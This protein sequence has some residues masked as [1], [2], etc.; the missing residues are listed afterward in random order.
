MPDKYNYSTLL[1]ASDFEKYVTL[2]GTYAIVVANAARSVASDI[3]IVIPLT[4]ERF[5][6]SDD[7][8][9]SNYF[10]RFTRALFEYFDNSFDKGFNCSLLMN[11]KQTP[12][13]IEE[14][15]PDSIIAVNEQNNADVFYAGTH[16]ALSE[17]I[18]SLSKLFKSCPENYIFEWTPNREL[19]GNALSVAYVYSYYSLLNDKSVSAFVTDLSQED[20]NLRDISHILK[21]IDASEGED[22]PDMLTSFF[23]KTSWSEILGTGTTVSTAVKHYFNSTP[24]LNTNESFFGEFLYFDP[25]TTNG[26]QTWQRGINCTGIETEYTQEHSRAL[27]ADISLYG[28]ESYGE[29][30]YVFEYPENM[31]YTNN[32]R[33]RFNVSDNSEDSLYEVKFILGNSQNKLE[34]SCIVSGNEMQEM[35]VDVSECASA[36]MID[37]IKLSVRSLDGSAEKCSLWL[38]EVCGLSNE[39]NSEELSELVS[40]E[41]DKIRDYAASEEDDGYWGSISLAIGIVLIIGVL[42]F[43]LFVSLNRE[44]KT[45]NDTEGSND[46]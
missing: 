1:S 45:N 42:G 26:A 16:H 11:S 43:G 8:D 12:L 24:R 22:I 39:Y 9:G 15:T 20:N 7:E 40:A 38:Y 36:N 27:K 4:F 5:F 17:Y 32:L 21:Y 25:N 13:G 41:R 14:L 2:C 30:L 18:V 3:D 46:K 34:S 29:L 28:T 19:R 33:L 37:F 31:I 6:E 44:N 10:K 35:F 23:D